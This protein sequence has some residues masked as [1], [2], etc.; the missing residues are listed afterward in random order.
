MVSFV[1]PRDS[2]RKLKI[3]NLVQTDMGGI[4]EMTRQEEKR[5]RVF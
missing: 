3:A 2:N 1:C 4:T 5:G